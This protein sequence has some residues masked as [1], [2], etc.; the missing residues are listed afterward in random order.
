MRVDGGDASQCTGRS[1]APYPGSG[2]GQA[3]AWSHPFHALAPD[4]TRR[5][6]GGDTL[7]IGGGSYMIGQGA[8]GAGACLP[9]NCSL[10]TVPGG[11]AGAPTR[12]L[13]D[14]AHRPRL[15]GTLGVTRILSL[16]GSSNV[17]IGHL[18]ITDQD[19][20]VYSHSNA[21][22]KCP[23]VGLGAWAK[24]GVYARASAN[25]WLH[26]LD[27]HGL[28]HTGLWAGGLSNWT[29]ERV[30]LNR[31][32]R[33]GWDANIGT[34]SSN[35]GA[36][37]LRGME[38]AWN[39]CGERW[40]TGAAWACWSQ[41]AGGYGDGLGTVAT[42][43]LWLIEDSFVH[44]N[45]QDGL[46]LRFLDGA[47]TTHATLRRIHAVG[48]AGN[49]V[50]VKG[51]SLIE[52]SVLIGNCGYFNGK[53]YMLAADN[54]RADGTTLLL[55]FTANDLAVVR[56]NSITGEG[57]SLVGATEGD[58]SGRALVQNNVLAGFPWF[59]NP[60]DLSRVQAGTSPALVT[61]SGNLVWNVYANAC[62]GDS[63]CGQNPALKD[64]ALA[65]YD[66][67]PLPGSPVVD[68][69]APMAQVTTDFL[70]HSRPLGAA[71]DI[72]AYE[73]PAAITCTRATP[74]VALAGFPAAVPA[75]TRIDYTLTLT[76]H[77]SAGCPTTSFTLSGSVPAGWSSTLGA[78]SLDLAPGNTGSTTVSVTS[79][80]SAAGGD[81][82]VGA[83]VASSAHSR[84]TASATATYSVLVPDPV[85]TPAA[86]T[87]SLGGPTDAVP[88]GTSIQYTANLRNNDSA[89]CATTYF[90]LADSTPAG[91]TATLAM[92]GLT[93]AP[94]ASGSTTLT[95]A[96]PS[97]ATPGGYGIGA[98]AS[99]DAGAV[100]T[101][102]AG[103]TYN[104]AEPPAPCTR[105]APTLA[106]GGPTAPVPAGSGVDYTINLH[107]NDSS[108]CAGTSFSLAASVPAGWTGLLAADTITLAPGASGGTTLAVTSAIDAGAGSYTI[109]SGVGSGAGGVHTASA[110]ATYTVDEPA[111]ACT[112][113][114]PTM[115]VGGPTAAVSPGSVVDYTVGI[116]NNDSSSCVGT[117]FSLA[118]SVPAGWTGLL[119]ADAITLAPGASG[120]TTLT[121]TSATDTSAGDYTI[122][123]GAGSSA[124]T[125]HTANA[126]AT[127]TVDVP[128]PVCTRAAPV[129]SLGGP[130]TAVVAGTAVAYTLS[131]SNQDSSACAATSFNL[132]RTVPAG[133]AG[134]LTATSIDLAPGASSSTTLTVTSAGT[135][136]AGPYAIGA[137]VDSSVGSV[138]AGNASATYTVA[139]PPPVCTRAA[140]VVSLGGPTAAVAAGTA[141]AYT[142]SVSNQ[143]SSACESTNFNLSRTVP[144]GWA[145]TLAAT[146]I[147]LAPGASSSTTLTVTSAGTAAAGPYAI[148]AGVD[149]SVGSVHAGN[150]SATYT[151]AVP[152]PV[153][154]RAAPVVSLGGPTAAVAAGTAVAYT[155][156]VTNQDSSACE[157]TNFNLSRTVPTGWA[158][159]LAATSISLAPGASSSTT[160]TVTSAGTATAGP[161]AIGA[162]VDSSIGSAHTGNASATY[163]VAAPPPVCT[164]AT[165]TLSMSGP[166][167]AV[168]AGTAVD[169]TVS[170][171]NRD[172][173]ACTPTSFN[174]TRAVPSGW[175]GTLTATSLSLA[176][177]ASGSTTLRVTSTGTA[178]AGS[179]TISTSAGSNAGAVHTASASTSYTIAA[180]AIVLTTT[181]TTDRATYAARGTVQ[182]AALLRNNA[183][184]VAGVPVTFTL[185]RPGGATSTLTATSGS[186]GYAR[187][188]YKIPSNKA[189]LGLY[190]ITARWSFGGVSASAVRTFTVL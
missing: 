113:A 180:P 111:P 11:T 93:L 45:T 148:G 117:S 105:S 166:T 138:H 75:G 171:V 59:L 149:S 28:G 155:L 139:V 121:V 160:L 110:S 22:A 119:A 1:D 33:A 188:T 177:G 67:E 56:H 178:A 39:G 137:G 42:G 23:A 62:P 73:L 49:Q 2:T 152:P 164:R 124:G 132:S 109:G 168:A 64:M 68:R 159:T 57:W 71:S 187:T 31:N 95:V 9:A 36:I 44:H 161:Y 165:P 147:S 142:L 16:D 125:V 135:A 37:V 32:G 38:I 48:N 146:S 88:A 184:A 143:D 141:V 106:L 58:S 6:A 91:W 29:L 14:P 108:T 76:N 179:Y 158:G 100:H 94:G 123:A 52:N 145:G 175:T 99:S 24:H 79:P 78:G 107:N 10:A 26:D 84:H 103:I 8:S 19:D 167:S 134:T 12:I 133:W 144:T 25:V 96:S 41:Q 172:S 170:L 86:P 116:R 60:A 186:D 136:P 102:S 153:C 4:G 5:I 65:T 118:A 15:W 189:A 34:G 74:T 80:A 173:A 43:G 47:D 154:T 20:C 30:Q 3:C 35:S 128:T 50:K 40:Q 53:F 176:A 46:D 70:L 27:I 85:C 151:V 97:D 190:T 51:N 92:P 87:L 101:A 18:E 182:I 162:S 115:T 66:A 82:T 129:V 150:A 55:V 122:G 90:N 112:R 83:G 7:R 61:H 104:V 114:A 185:A 131:V 127:Y 13:G 174:L 17:E 140:P 81:Y 63:L 72:G 126:S 77:D 130:T 89:S 120:G 21:T 157:S 181:L 163:T 156:S 169:Y 54:C 183:V 69:V 98:G